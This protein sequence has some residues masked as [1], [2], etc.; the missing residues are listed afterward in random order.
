MFITHYCR[1]TKCPFQ[2]NE[3]KWKSRI[4]II[5]ENTSSRKLD[6]KLKCICVKIGACYDTG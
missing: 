4:L 2:V 6:E 1:S 3:S 5:K